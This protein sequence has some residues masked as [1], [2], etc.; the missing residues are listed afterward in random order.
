MIERKIEDYVKYI[1]N[2]PFQNMYDVATKMF[3]QNTLYGEKKKIAI[4]EL[5]FL[6]DTKR[7]VVKQI[8]FEK[9][10]CTIDVDNVLLGISP[11]TL[12]VDKIVLDKITKIFKGRGL[13]D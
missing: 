13:D 10:G 4:P 5:S 7:A 2:N 1:V 12:G 6:S 9:T 8:V 3:G 11:F